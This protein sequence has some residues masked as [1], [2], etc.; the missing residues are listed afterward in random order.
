[1]SVFQSE[2]QPTSR[3][4]N[5][6]LATM[7][8][9]LL[10]GLMLILL[11]GSVIAQGDTPQVKLSDR[12]TS[13]AQR[14]QKLQELLLRLAEM[15]VT[16][17]PERAALLRR[18]ARQ[19]SDQFIL[20]KLKI[21]SNSL[22]T[23]EYQKAV[24]NQEAATKELGNL[25]TLLMSE[26]RSERIRA[27]KDRIQ[28][29]VKDLKRT[30]NNQRSVRA[31]T[32]NGAELEQLQKE[33]KSVTERGEQLL[34]QLDS[35]SESDSTNES[36]G[37]SPESNDSQDTESMP[38]DE[39]EASQ[40][41]EE[42]ANSP[43]ENQS[44]EGSSEQT[45]KSPSD[46]AN[47]NDQAGSED[48][49]KTT[50][51]SPSESQSENQP[52]AE[53]QPKDG[54]DEKQ[55]NKDPRNSSDP[56]SDPSDSGEQ[57]QGHPSESSESPPS[58]SENSPPSQSQSGQ[59]NQQ[60]SPPSQSSPQPQTPEQRAQQQ[61]QQAIE[62]MQE[63]E[64]ALEEAKRP[65]A[66]EQQRAAE[67][68]LR[69]AIDEL[70][71]ILRQLREEEMQR[72]LARLEGRLK[73]MATMQSK[74]LDDTVALAATPPTQRDRQTDLK[75][76]ELAFEEKKITLEADRAMLLLREE[77]SSVAFPEVVGQIRED[78]IR[79]SSLLN[80]TKVDAVS[81]GIQQDILA[82]L[83]EMIA[84]L[85]KAQRDL[86]EQRQQDQ[87][88]GSPPPSGQSQQPL[89]EAIAEL[90]LIRTMQIRIQGTTN[91]Y[92]DLI[93]EGQ[94]TGEELLP[95]LRDLAERQ[96][97]LDQITRDIALERNQ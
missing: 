88:P 75:A 5:Q 43:S 21:A 38:T 89:V 64:R 37:T 66:T 67:E 79:V 10:I 1:M 12:Q 20:E 52:N 31:R 46:S 53:R 2:T 83:E 91:R 78:T 87:P 73:K 29:M 32:E 36:E 11:A 90:K 3:W 9:P 58:D 74:V 39:S 97:R 60:S 72:E 47:D 86:E 92:S 7:A 59:P 70:D 93:D 63:A 65:E 13:V 17:N 23:E 96:D 84:A 51:S 69:E 71:K 48:G 44:S 16:E 80:D 27:E 54:E 62:K 28:Q 55:E 94:S 19:S 8:K 81:Q 76:G 61:L 18:A 25:L 30:L 95:L 34:N 22:E 56:K 68:D 82:A 14:F 41:A 6:T 15:E 35:E 26:D 40:P 33:Q 24:D 45:N 4:V 42:S 49:S 57:S 77:G 50:E 85:Q